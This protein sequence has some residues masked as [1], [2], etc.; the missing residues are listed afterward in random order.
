M[1]SRVPIL[2]ILFVLMIGPR[3]L[4][5]KPLD[6]T[7]TPNSGPEGTRVE[8]HGTHL[9]TTRAVLFGKIPALFRV[10]SESLVTALVPL[11]APSC[12]LTI[13]T[14][15]Q[16]LSTPDFFVKNDPRIPDEVRYKTGYVNILPR[17]QNFRVVLLWGIAIAGN[18]DTDQPAQNNAK[19]EIAWTTLSCRIDGR[20][21]MLSHDIGKIRGGLYLR[22]PWFHDNS[23]EHM[24]LDTAPNNDSH[25]PVALLNIKKRP[26]R[27]WHFW[28]YSGRA[29]PPAGELE[30]C[31]ASARV[32]ISGGALLQLGMDYW[33][34]QTSLWAP[35]SQNNHEAGVSH[36]YFPSPD[37]Q[38]VVFTDI[39]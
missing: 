25:G 7:I 15:E 3:V 14:T 22:N 17:P 16:R 12:P 34:D 28:S 38:E 13:V 10:D 20:D 1:G 26:D 21:L 6:T 4:A 24:P 2:T 11:H 18:P 32:R 23:H 36:W 27:I 37:W 8:I 35:H 39:Q 5:Q 30:G 31:R 9:A 29:N 19:V 33:R